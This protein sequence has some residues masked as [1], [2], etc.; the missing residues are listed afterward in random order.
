MYANL[1]IV[2]IELLL[3]L[4][5]CKIFTGWLSSYANNF[6]FCLLT[7]SY[8]SSFTTI[9]IFSLLPQKQHFLKIFLKIWRVCFW[10]SRNRNTN[11]FTNEEYYIFIY[12]SKG[13][14][15]IYISYIYIYI[16]IHFL[17]S[18]RSIFYN[19]YTCIPLKSYL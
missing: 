6:F 14:Q 13:I 2:E 7:C 9:F 4:L 1:W 16:C 11:G 8:E 19:L 3:I 10:I 5:R 15:S 17:K 12:W 18:G